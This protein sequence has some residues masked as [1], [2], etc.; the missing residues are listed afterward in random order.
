M[1]SVDR[2]EAAW[3]GI[4]KSWTLVFSKAWSNLLV[5][6][7]SPFVSGCRPPRVFLCED[8]EHLAVCPFNL[9]QRDSV[10]ARKGG[11]HILSEEQACVS[12]VCFEG[13]QVADLEGG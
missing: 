9:L 4:S 11:T 8:A 12:F 3:S 2:P 5:S 7:R 10:T 13:A 6:G 1:L